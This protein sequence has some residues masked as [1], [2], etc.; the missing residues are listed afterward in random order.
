MTNPDPM[1]LYGSLLSTICHCEDPHRLQTL[2]KEFMAL[3]QKI[4]LKYQLE[5]ELAL[6]DLFFE[7]EAYYPDDDEVWDTVYADICAN[8]AQLRKAAE[9]TLR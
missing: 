1:S 9:I 4:N 2:A 3:Y 6:S 7:C 8:S 5:E